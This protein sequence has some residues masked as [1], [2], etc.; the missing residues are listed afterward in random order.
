MQISLVTL[1]RGAILLWLLLWA[2][3]AGAQP[4]QR[5]NFNVDNERSTGGPASS[6]ASFTPLGL[7][8]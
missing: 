8:H 4:A 2:T 5:S 1:A 6:D 3:T 7:H